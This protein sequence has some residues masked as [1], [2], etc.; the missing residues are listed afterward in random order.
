MV[1]AETSRPTQDVGK[2]RR[3]YAAASDHGRGSWSSV[4]HNGPGSAEGRIA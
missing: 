3:A 1:R 4:R 2:D